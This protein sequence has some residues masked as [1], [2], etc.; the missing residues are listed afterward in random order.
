MTFTI[1]TKKKF[2]I[3]DIDVDKILVSKNEQY[4]NCNS[5]NYFIG[6]ND[7]V[8][9]PLYLFHKRLDILINLKK[10]K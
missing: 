7:N 4:G 8:I 1:G 2:N 9:R 5:Y 6:Y 10:I 3:D